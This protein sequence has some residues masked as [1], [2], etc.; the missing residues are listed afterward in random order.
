M[1]AA[2]ILYV[3]GTFRG[4]VYDK[5]ESATLLW[6]ISGAFSVCAIALSLITLVGY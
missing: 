6:L 2:T 3:I 4:F 1:A 5:Y